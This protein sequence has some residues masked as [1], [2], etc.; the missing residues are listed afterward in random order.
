[1]FEDYDYSYVDP[2]DKKT[3]HIALKKGDLVMP[4][5]MG[6]QRHPDNWTGTDPDVW[7]PQ[8]WLDDINGG[9][10]HLFAFGPFGNG[11]RRC[12]GERLALGET[13]L[14]LASLLRKYDIVPGKYEFQA[15]SD[16]T[17]S[18]KYGVVIKLQPIK[19]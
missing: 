11:P 10:K 2:V 8:R 13:R 7:D 5:L 15:K 6:A 4:F 12:V 3:K 16:A 19:A 18:A 9:A 14:I 17:I 1:M